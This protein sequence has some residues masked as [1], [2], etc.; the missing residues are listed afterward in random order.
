[1]RTNQENMET[2]SR[3]A[4]E[5]ARTSLVGF[6]IG[7]AAAALLAA[8]A[9]WQLLRAV[10]RPIRDLTDATTAI[11]AGQLHRTVPQLGTDELGRLAAAFNVMSEHL[12]VYRQSSA[13][14]LIR[15]QRTAQATIDSFPDPALVAAPER[16]VA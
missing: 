5:T 10:L 2:A 12:R 7:V 6:S 15:A 14:R 9:G 1:L 3:K 4:R 8:L 16:R 13:D 11:G